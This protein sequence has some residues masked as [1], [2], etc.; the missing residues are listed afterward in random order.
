MLNILS[1]RDIALLV[2]YIHTVSSKSS[3]SKASGSVVSCYVLHKYIAS[4]I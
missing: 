2:A 1:I 3:G 4:E